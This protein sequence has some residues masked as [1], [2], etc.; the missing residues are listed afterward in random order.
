M[1]TNIGNMIAASCTLGLVYAERM[2]KD[3][4]ADDFARFAR[5]GGQLV[6]SNHAAFVF[7][8]LSLYPPRIIE[9]LGGDPAGI[10]PPADFESLFS[11]DATCQDDPQGTVYP[12]KDVVVNTFFTGYQAA[13]ESLRSADDA[14]FLEPNPVPG[15]IRERFPTKGAMHAFYVSGHMM[16]H[17]GQLSAWRR[18][19]GLGPG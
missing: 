7:G 6:T 3:V 8:H 14:V 4:S 11:K 15:P 13:I 18:M 12:A 5:P 19:L 1:A 16:G 17:L 9:H 2:L 10:L